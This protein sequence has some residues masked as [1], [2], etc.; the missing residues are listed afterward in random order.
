MVIV[1]SDGG[2]F[3]SS[4]GKGRIQVKC[5]EERTDVMD[6]RLRFRVVPSA[7]ALALGPVA[8]I[9]QH[10]FRANGVRHGAE[11]WDFLQIAGK[12][13]KTLSISLE[14]LPLNSP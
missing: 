13:A 8:G 6:S 7:V 1:P 14:L 4:K 2:S 10:D 3:R 11:E 5:E 12:A 9:I